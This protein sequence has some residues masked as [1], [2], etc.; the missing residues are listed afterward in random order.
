MRS[1][2]VTD[3]VVTSIDDAGLALFE[4][5]LAQ[6]HHWLFV[7]VDGNMPPLDAHLRFLDE[8]LAGYR[9]GAMAHAGAL[10]FEIA[11]NWKLVHENF[12]EPY[13]VF[14]AHPRLHTFQDTDIFVLKSAQNTKALARAV[15]RLG[16]KLTDAQEKEIHAGKDFAQLRNGPFD[17]DL[18]FAPDGIESFEEAW[19]AGRNIEDYP[20]C[21][22]DDIIESKRSANRTK[23]RE[24]LARLEDF[25]RY[26]DIEGRRPGT[27]LPPLRTTTEGAM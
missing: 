20:V 14:A 6:W 21:S 13:H 27:P 3:P 9:I 18:V 7:N 23:D 24:S 10:E 25:R 1:T 16:F 12:I 17:L 8:K 26:L 22:L 2:C 11:A 5:P 4:A 15:R 19:R